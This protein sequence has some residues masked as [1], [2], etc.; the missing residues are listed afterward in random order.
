M[1]QN[2][3]YGNNPGGVQAAEQTSLNS[4]RNYAMALQAAQRA[5]QQL[6]LQSRQLGMAERNNQANIAMAPAQMQLDRLKTLANRDI[7]LSRDKTNQDYYSGLLD[8]GHAEIKSREKIAAMNQVGKMGAQDR[9]WSMEDSENL[10]KDLKES[11][12]EGGNETVE[13]MG[14]YIDPLSQPQWKQGLVRSITP[15]IAKLTPEQKQI[16]L[17][18][19]VPFVSQISQPEKHELA[20]VLE[21]YTPGF[22]PQEKKQLIGAI[23]PYIPRLNQTQRH[24]LTREIDLYHRYMNSRYDNGVK[25]AANY[26]QK[27]KLMVD[28]DAEPT[29][30]IKVFKDL[31]TEIR[32]L[33]L[34]I[35]PDIANMKFVPV[36]SKFGGPRKDY[37][38]MAKKSMVPNSN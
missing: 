30:K 26:N 9:S 8:K 37:T 31:E 7:A 3:V 34:P 11:I 2:F 28:E 38:G 17:R 36:K 6:G 22:T 19:I 12:Y 29:E 32:R 4:D 25:E 20:R 18:D 35:F 14:Q 15:R 5:A 24:D 16:F 33:G 1:A 23:E 21:P 27:F 13:D 10:Y